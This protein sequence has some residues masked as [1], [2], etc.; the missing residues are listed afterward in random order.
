MSDEI[1]LL[2]DDP[3]TLNFLESVLTGAGFICRTVGDP[4][5]ALAAVRARREIAIVLSDIYM[6]GLT[7]LQFVDQLN[8]LALA[9]PVPAV[10]LLTAHPTLESAI[11]ALRL[12]A[13]DFL[14]KPVTPRELVDVVTRVLERVRRQRAENSGK[15]PDVEIL[16]RQAEEIAGALRRFTQAPEPRRAPPVEPPAEGHDP[17]TN[18]TTIEAT[19]PKGRISVLDAIE[20]LRKLRRHYDDHKLDDVAWDLLLEMLRA[21]QKQMRLSV[22]ALT[23]SIPGVSSTTSLR[24]VSELTARGYIERVPDARDGRRDFVRLTAKARELLVDYLAHADSCLVDIQSDERSRAPSTGR[25]R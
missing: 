19:W 8:S 10:L 16:I 3:V 11:D 5:Q 21:E 24:R 7:G 18:R 20:G 4:E 22:S 13:C 17:G 15:T 9:W 14:T 6:P 2:D 23:I 12:G 25:R 1:L